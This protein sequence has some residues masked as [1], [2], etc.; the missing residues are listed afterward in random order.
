MAYTIERIVG[1]SCDYSSTYVA[2]SQGHTT[3]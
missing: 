1:A 2:Y 3:Q